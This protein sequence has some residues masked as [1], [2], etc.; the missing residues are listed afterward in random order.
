MVT[1]ISL[2]HCLSPAR[3]D[4]N[5]ETIIQ[6]CEARVIGLCWDIMRC[7][8][9]CS[10]CEH[11]ESVQASGA[12]APIIYPMEAMG[13]GWEHQIS[14]FRRVGR[15]GRIG[16]SGAGRPRGLCGWWFRSQHADY[17]GLLLPSARG[18]MKFTTLGGTRI[19]R[20]A[21]DRACCMKHG[22]MNWWTN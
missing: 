16:R 22:S 12:I 11:C 21:L 2:V 6:G 13:R 4:E 8:Q 7:L 10:T 20:F 9:L 1:Y 14:L 17:E 18:K 15:I 19:E 3:W 5:S